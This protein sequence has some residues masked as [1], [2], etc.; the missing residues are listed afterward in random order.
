MTR[1]KTVSL[2]AAFTL[3]AASCLL[4]ACASFTQPAAQAPATSSGTT[5]DEYQNLP[6][7]PLLSEPY[8]PQDNPLLSASSTLV[9]GKQE[10]VL[11]DAQFSASDAQ[12]L[13]GR[14][15]ALGKRLTTIYITQGEPE[16]YFGLSTLKEAFPEARVVARPH[17]VA[18]IRASGKSLQDIWRPQMG[19]DAPSNIV[20]PEPLNE[21][22]I[23]LERQSLRILGDSASASPSTPEFIWIPSIRTVVG[24]HLVYSG[25]HV[26]LAEAAS[27]EARAV[28]LKALERMESLNPDVVIP[29][30]HSGSGQMNLDAVRFTA[31]YIRAFDE[32]NLRTRNASGLIEAMRTRFPGLRGNGTLEL[33]ARVIKGELNLR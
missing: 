28:W 29:G 10:A 19:S 4:S 13:A 5:P 8:L 12:R 1:H 30:H 31:D 3:L 7:P 18:Q 20:I 15:Q 14:I 32:E 11:I 9:M 26:N 17:T 24:G 23:L 22:R 21:D 16:H 27:T 33:S 2:T 6:T 25:E